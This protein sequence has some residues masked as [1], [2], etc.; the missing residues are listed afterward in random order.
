M[1]LA[2]RR[3]RVSICLAPR[4]E[5]PDGPKIGK[6]SCVV[7]RNRCSTDVQQMLFYSTPVLS[8]SRRTAAGAAKVGCASTSARHVHLPKGRVGRSP[9]SQDCLNKPKSPYK[10]AVMASGAAPA[11][12]AVDP[13][14][15]FALASAA[16]TSLA[17][18]PSTFGF[19][20]DSIFIC[21]YLPRVFEFIHCVLGGCIFDP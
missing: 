8:C 3:P 11:S 12:S 20:S 10:A 4:Y 21:I 14:P 2:E 17:S 15:S 7:K 1:F 5:G 13:S 16:V 19:N 18:A 9:S 6:D